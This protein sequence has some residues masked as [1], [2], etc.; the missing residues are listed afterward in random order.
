[1]RAPQIVRACVKL[2]ALVIAPASVAGAQLANASTAATALGGAFTARATGYNAVAWNP[3]NLAMPG[4]PGFSFTI[5]AIDGGA[6]LKPIDFNRLAPFSGKLIPA[7]TREQWMV[8]IAAD[9]GQKGNIGGGVTELG[10][11][12]GMFAFQA[13]TKVSTD[14]N[15]APDF[16]EAILFGNAGR[17]PGTVKNLNFAGTSFHAAAYSTG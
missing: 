15:L 6:G 9:S 17:N 1:M 14:L 11:S 5:G 12:L 8:D 10:F 3:A 13:N 4:N 16:M 2:S 7:A